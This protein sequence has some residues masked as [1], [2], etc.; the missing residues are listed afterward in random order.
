MFARTTIFATIACLMGAA[1]VAAAALAAHGGGATQAA[2]AAQM[3]MVHAA[4]SLA[5]VSFVGSQRL[6]VVAIAAMQAGA[7]LFALDMA[8]RIWLGQA[9]FAMAAP[10]G[11]TL[12]ILAWLVAALA[13]VMRE[14]T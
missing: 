10:I 14:K 5:L 8:A 12:V 13:I 2:A 6:G 9:L 3:L 1:G 4:A 11:G 7:I